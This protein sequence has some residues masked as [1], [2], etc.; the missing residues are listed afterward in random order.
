MNL[1][2]EKIAPTLRISRR[3][4]GSEPFDL[5][6]AEYNR[7]LKEL[8][9]SRGIEV[10]EIERIDGINATSIRR[11]ISEGRLEEYRSWMPESSYEFCKRK[12]R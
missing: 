4:V 10:V 7:R 12:V 5:V 9:P 11:A 3:F 1:F 6:T 8:L 2:A